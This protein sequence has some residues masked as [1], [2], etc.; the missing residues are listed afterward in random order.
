MTVTAIKFFRNS[1]LIRRIQQKRNLEKKLETSAGIEP[2]SLAQQ[3]GTL[4]ITPNC[5]LCLY[6]AEIQSYSCM[7]DSVQFV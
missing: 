3:S 4:T 1:H 2:R 7:G 6:E 5:F